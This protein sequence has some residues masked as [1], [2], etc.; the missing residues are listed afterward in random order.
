[1]SS[2]D[3][4]L[5]PEIGFTKAHMLDYYLRVA[6]VLLPHVE[7]R[8]LTLHRFPEGVGGPHFFQTRTPPHPDWLRVQ[9]MH[10]FTS[11]KHVEAPVIDDLRGLVWAVH[12][13][14]IELHPFLARAD[15][16]ERPDRVVFDLDPGAPAEL[17]DACRVA[18]SLREGLDGLGLR[19]HPKT[20]G[21]KGLHVHVPIEPVH[22]W[23]ATKAFARA[24][25]GLLTRG[26][27]DRVVDRMP[28]AARAG[29]VFVDWSQND[30]GKSTVAPYSLR[31]LA[32]PT[33]ATPVSWEEVEAAVDAGSADGLWFGPDDVLDRVEGLGDLMAPALEATQR[34][35][36]VA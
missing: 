7:G 21:A 33:V 12:L 1:M 15:R 4:V 19:S 8:P 22:P 11:G 36:G 34:L 23:A 10:T 17:L 28:K 25:A 13:T 14:T 32:L 29:R 18:L 2:L 20:S 31:G 5:W 26:D 35:P 24:V 6:P 3:R 27:P 30:P 9:A 16:L